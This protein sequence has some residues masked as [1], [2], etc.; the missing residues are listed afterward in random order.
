MNTRHVMIFLC[1]ESLQ[2]PFLC[3]VFW[4]FSAWLTVAEEAQQACRRI[5]R[6]N[7][8]VDTWKRSKQ[9]LSALDRSM[10]QYF[11]FNRLV[12]LFHGN[13]TMFFS[14]VS[15]VR[16]SLGNLRA[17]RAQLLF[18]YV[19]TGIAK[20]RVF[21]RLQANYRHERFCLFLLTPFRRS[22]GSS[23]SDPARSLAGPG[24]YRWRGEST[25]TFVVAAAALVMAVMVLVMISLASLA[26]VRFTEALKNLDIPPF[27]LRNLTGGNNSFAKKK[28][29][30]APRTSQMHSVSSCRIL[31]YEA[32]RMSTCC[33]ILPPENHGKGGRVRPGDGVLLPAGATSPVQRLGERNGYDQ[34]RHLASDG[35]ILERQVLRGGPSDRDPGSRIKNQGLRR[36]YLPRV[37][38][39][40]PFLLSSEEIF[41]FPASI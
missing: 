15:C 6:S 12:G 18:Q 33:A 21:V 3:Q 37:V 36:R 13:N 22:S 1:I 26:R 17:V 35:P 41:L 5:E 23:F 9:Y 38:A 7:D 25:S 24:K 28:G 2:N 29:T 40:C 30:E 19:W 39:H 4:V 20:S 14:S 34:E 10:A 8:D 27:C 11:T 31:T 16:L 32:C